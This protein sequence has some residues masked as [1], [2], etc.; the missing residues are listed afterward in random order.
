MAVC[1]GAMMVGSIHA[2]VQEGE[3]V[4]RGQEFGYF[5]FGKLLSHLIAHIKSDSIHCALQV[6]QLLCASS[7]RAWLSGMK[8]FSSMAVRRLKRLYVSVW[9]L[10]VH[11]DP[12]TQTVLLTATV[13]LQSADRARSRRTQWSP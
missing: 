2:T 10:A 3:E 12:Q 7:R 13:T 4:K 11:G 1:V 9:V 5:A 6:A 8:I